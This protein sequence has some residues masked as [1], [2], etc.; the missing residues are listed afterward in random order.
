MVTLIPLY[1]T[2][3]AGSL[4]T[5]YSTMSFMW[6]NASTFTYKL[7]VWEGAIL[8]VQWYSI[9]AIKEIMVSSGKWCSSREDF[10]NPPHTHKRAIQSTC[11]HYHLIELGW[12]KKGTV[13]WRLWSCEGQLRDAR[14]ELRKHV[15]AFNCA[16]CTQTWDIDQSLQLQTFGVPV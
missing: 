13:C 7:E 14:L 12:I 15:V 9:Q 11:Y 1:F 16:S 8:R 5:A 3:A 4:S 2:S 10:E 6:L